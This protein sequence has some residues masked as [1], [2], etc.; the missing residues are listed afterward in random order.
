MPSPS[1]HDL[2]TQ[3]LADEIR[4]LLITANTGGIGALV[5]LSASLAEKSVQPG[6]AIAP[7]VIFLVGILLAAISMFLA[8]YREIKLR[9]AEESAEPRP[10]F[11]TIAWSWI[12]NGLSL[13]AFIAASAV[14]LCSLAHVSV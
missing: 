8:Q 2:R 13:L 4:R 6:W 7:L 10:H 12:W 5:L 11:D 9:Q 14:S 3:A 1:P